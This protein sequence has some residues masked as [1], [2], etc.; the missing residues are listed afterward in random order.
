[1]LQARRCQGVVERDG[2]ARAGHVRGVVVG[3]RA[4]GAQPQDK[5]WSKITDHPW[6][7]RVGAGQ[8]CH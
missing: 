8:Q 7:H 3:R 1:M 6:D 2:G 5:H 4:V